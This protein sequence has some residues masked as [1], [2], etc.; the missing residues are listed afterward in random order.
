[1]CNLLLIVYCDGAASVMTTTATEE[2]KGLEGGFEDCEN[3]GLVK[4]DHWPQMLRS[5]A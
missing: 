2:N 5:S 3:L 1:M 4:Y